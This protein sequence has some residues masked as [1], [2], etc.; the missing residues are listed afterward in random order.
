MQMMQGWPMNLP[1]NL[2]ADNLT[3]AAAWLALSLSILTILRERTRVALW[4]TVHNQKEEVAFDELQGPIF[5]YYNT[6]VVHV[7]NKG[8]QPA[9]LLEVR[10]AGYDRGLFGRLRRATFTRTIRDCNDQNSKT[11]RLDAGGLITIQGNPHSLPPE[12]HKQNVYVEIRH[13]KSKRWMRAP[14]ELPKH[15]D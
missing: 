10:V 11:E 4:A 14:L 9:T 5:T 2:N 1:Q 6:I 3:A 12:A 15:I 7:S 13:N 8:R